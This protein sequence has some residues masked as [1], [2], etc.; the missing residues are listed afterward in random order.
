VNVRRFYMNK[1]RRR[2]LIQGVW[3]SPRSDDKAAMREKLFE[4]GTKP[5]YHRDAHGPEFANEIRQAVRANEYNPDGLSVEAI[6]VEVARAFSRQGDEALLM[7]FLNGEQN[8]ILNR[9]GDPEIRRNKVRSVVD[10]LS[11]RYRAEATSDHLIQKGDQKLAETIAKSPILMLR[12]LQIQDA[13]CRW[14]YASRRGTDDVR[15]EAGRLLDAGIPVI[16]GKPTE[17]VYDAQL[18]LLAYRDLKRYVDAM[19]ECSRHVAGADELLKFFPDAARLEDP[20]NIPESLFDRARNLPAPNRVAASF[21]GKI[22]GVEEKRVL[23]MLTAARKRPAA[24]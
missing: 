11:E 13:V 14:L 8:M 24:R 7:R 17:A 6:E 19:I 5:V 10:F 4:A 12:S 16:R 1:K 22:C 9:P 23:G 20:Y 3:N 15:K 21:I 18:L 2:P